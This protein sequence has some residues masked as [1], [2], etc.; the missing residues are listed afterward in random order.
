ME[1]NKCD[2]SN[3]LERMV[4]VNGVDIQQWRQIQITVFR[5]ETIKQ[6]IPDARGKSRNLR[7]G[8]GSL[9]FPPFLPLPL[10]L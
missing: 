6:H 2:F 8:G 7:K 4:H 10:H 5:N 3:P 1:H 9:P